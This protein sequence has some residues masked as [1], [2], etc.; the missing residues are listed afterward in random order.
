MISLHSF[1]PVFQGQKRPWHIGLLFNRFSDTAL[2]LKNWF[3]SHEPLLNIGLNQ[4]YD[5]SDEDDY[6]IPVFGEQMGFAHVLIEIRQDLIERK[7]TQKNGLTFFH[8]LSW[9]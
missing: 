6:T 2:F 8:R 5:V 3:N 1:T 9:N 7:E 4:P